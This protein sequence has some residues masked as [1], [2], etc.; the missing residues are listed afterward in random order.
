MAATDGTSDLVQRQ[1]GF[2]SDHASVSG[3]GEPANAGESYGI[4]HAPN[5]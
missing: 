4:D 3:R 5:H 2:L 1:P